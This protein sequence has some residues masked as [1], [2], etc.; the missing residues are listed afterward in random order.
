ME[1]AGERQGAEDDELLLVLEPPELIIYL[2]PRKTQKA[3]FLG[4][5]NMVWIQ[6][7]HRCSRAGEC[8]LRL[9]WSSPGTAEARPGRDL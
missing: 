5:R 8:A 1:L 3:C 7:R 4:A 6:S 2:V 9:L